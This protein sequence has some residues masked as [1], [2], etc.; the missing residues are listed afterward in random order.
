MTLRKIFPVL[1]LALLLVSASTPVFA[2]VSDSETVLINKRPLGDLGD[3]TA[4]EIANGLDLNANFLIELAGQ[5]R[6]DGKIDRKTARFTRTEGDKRMGDL[7]RN[8]IEAISD[9]GFFAYVQSILGNQFTLQV[10][11]NDDTIGFEI[12]S[13]LATESVAKSRQSTLN[14]LFRVA[15]EEKARKAETVEE[16]DD[17]ILLKSMSVIAEGKKLII[18]SALPKVAAQNMIKSR[19]PINTQ[20]SE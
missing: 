5:L 16:K 18:R 7:A 2:Q 20:S 4:R 9:A 10:F 1:T 8:A 13:D 12:R 3:R 19:M 11:Q 17:L 6:K 15:Q 14:L